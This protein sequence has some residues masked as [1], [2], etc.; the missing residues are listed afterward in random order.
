MVLRYRAVNDARPGYPLF[1]LPK[2]SLFYV[3]LYIIPTGEKQWQEFLSKAG[4]RYM[5]KA[6]VIV[7]IAIV[8]IGGYLI[9][10]WHDKTKKRQLEPSITLYYWTDAK[11]QK[12]IS[13]SAPSQ[14]ARNVYTDKGYK[15]I[16]TPLAVTIKDK[17]VDVYRAIRKK[18][19]K[20][21][22]DKKG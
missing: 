10:D 7:I 20:P 8:G 14:N 22:K 2:R 4:D 18:L 12:H 19:I 21:K 3:K 11:G 13:D 15:H 5:R 9:W 6:L 1:E 16:R 17:A